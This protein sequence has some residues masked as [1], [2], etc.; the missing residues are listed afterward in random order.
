MGLINTDLNRIAVSMA[1][2]IKMLSEVE[3]GLR[4][5][6]DVFDY[7]E[8]FFTI[9]YICRVGILDRIE[10]NQW[11]QS[12]SIIIPTGLF[13]KRKATIASGLMDTVGKL[14][15]M[16]EDDALISDYVEDILKK[17]NCFHEFDKMVSAEQKRKL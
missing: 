10:K 17:G 4:H 7:K 13:T 3:T 1:N 16:V 15:S 11:T 9:A 5:N 6:C 8:N 2:V 12:M 14:K